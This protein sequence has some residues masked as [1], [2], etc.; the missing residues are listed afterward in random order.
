MKLIAT[1]VFGQVNEPPRKYA[2]IFFGWD[3]HT[4]KVVLFYCGNPDIDI[5]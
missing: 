5:S 2:L 3:L 1:L 4:Q